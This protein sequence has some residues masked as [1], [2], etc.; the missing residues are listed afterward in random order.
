V[1]WRTGAE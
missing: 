1:K